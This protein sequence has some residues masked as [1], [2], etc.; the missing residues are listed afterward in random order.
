VLVWSLVVVASLVLV[1]SITAN[2][3]QLAALDTDQVVQ[4]TDEILDDGDVQQALSVYAVD[5]L[6]ANVDVRG[7]LAQQLPGGAKALAAPAAAAVRQLAINVEQRALESPRVQEL[8]SRAVRRAH[9]QFVR[10]VRD[11][12][13]FVATGGGEVTLDY[14]SVIAD[15]AGR[16][17]VDPETISRLQGIVQD[18]SQ[19]LERRLTTA[20]SRI[21]SVRAALA[22]VEQGEL[23]PALRTDLETLE[24]SLAALQRQVASVDDKLKAAQ[25]KVPAPLQARLAQLEGRVAELDRR[26]AAARERTA[27]V[28]DDPSQANVDRL[29]A[30]LAQVEA[31]ISALLGRPIVQN[32][33]QLVIMRSSQLDG[34]QSVVA[35]LRNLGLVLPLLALLLYLGA[36]Y[37]AKGWRRRALIAVGAGI[38]A[39]TLLVLLVRRLTGSAV[40]DSLASSETVQ[41]AARSAW[42]IV[43]ST[44]RQRALS[45]LVI[46]VAFI[47]AGLLAGPGRRAIAIRRFLAPYLRDQPAAVYAIAAVLFLL[48]LAFMPGITNLAQILVIIA[49]AALAVAGVE[50]L[51]RQTAREFPPQPSSP[52]AAAPP[53]AH[54]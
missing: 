50:L 42:D 21:E 16:L 7:E 48:W 52:E 40:V 45:L 31:R 5:Q 35:A 30:S 18:V 54:T 1:V 39:A 47:A 19:R 8:V 32:P 10:L 22:E 23:S 3:V 26:L 44:L 6:Y 29:D 43:S 24:Q 49:L 14:G 41:P 28:L 20:Q 53:S 33:G 2:W 38:V 12:G 36:L 13:E 51:R 15:L 4:T 34:I 25:D 37:L 11:E 9:E 17:G 27:A 46:G